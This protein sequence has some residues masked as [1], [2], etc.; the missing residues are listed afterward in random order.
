M[1]D[2]HQAMAAQE[3]FVVPAASEDGLIKN[4]SGFLEL[5]SIFNAQRLLIRSYRAN[6]NIGI[7]T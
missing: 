3:L 1:S 7:N 5:R 2:V 4:S 6:I